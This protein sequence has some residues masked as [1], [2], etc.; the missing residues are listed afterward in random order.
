MVC[1]GHHDMRAPTPFKKYVQAFITFKKENDNK[2]FVNL[3][4]M[5]T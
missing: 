4:N 2:S 5:G 3:N 1:L